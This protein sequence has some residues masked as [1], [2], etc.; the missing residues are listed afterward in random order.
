VQYRP[1]FNNHFGSQ[2]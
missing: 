1:K 2:D